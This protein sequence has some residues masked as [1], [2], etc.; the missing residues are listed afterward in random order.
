MAMEQA[1]SVVFARLCWAMLSVVESVRCRIGVQGVCGGGEEGVAAAKVGCGWSWYTE[2]IDRRKGAARVRAVRVLA[3]GM[4]LGMW[5][6]GMV[7]W[8]GKGEKGGW[9]SMGDGQ[10]RR[11]E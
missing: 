4:W 7:G 6:G 11:E 1:H 3:D 9:K 8:E 10:C 5:E 2:M